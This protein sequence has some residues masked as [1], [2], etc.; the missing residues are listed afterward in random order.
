M[1]QIQYSIHG[2][3]GSISIKDCPFFGVSVKKDIRQCQGIKHCAFADPDFIK[4][5]HN[6]VDMESATFIKF[7]QNQNQNNIKIKTY[8]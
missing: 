6:E 4:E 2:T 8:T 3:G 1:L 7:N 5:Q